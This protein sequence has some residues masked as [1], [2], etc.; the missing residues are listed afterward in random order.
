MFFNMVRVNESK[1]FLKSNIC[2]FIKVNFVDE[3]CVSNSNESRRK[4]LKLIYIT[5][6]DY[7]DIG[8]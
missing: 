3:I 8:T 2:K 5:L 6:A 7:L 4:C 1:A